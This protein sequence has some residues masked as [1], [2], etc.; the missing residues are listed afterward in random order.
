MSGA[1]GSGTPRSDCALTPGPQITRK[2]PA[3]GARCRGCKAAGHTADAA[4]FG[5]SAA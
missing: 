5:A 4:P 3:C 1:T 2:S